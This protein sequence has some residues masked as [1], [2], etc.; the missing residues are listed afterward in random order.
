MFDFE[1]I[2]VFLQQDVKQKKDTTP[3]EETKRQ[4][5]RVGQE[6]RRKGMKIKLL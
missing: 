3:V 2:C 1:G 6:N 5:V 4:K